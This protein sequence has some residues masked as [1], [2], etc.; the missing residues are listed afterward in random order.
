[1]AVGK[2][3]TAIIKAEAPKFFLRGSDQLILVIV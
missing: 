2:R 3:Q 1:M